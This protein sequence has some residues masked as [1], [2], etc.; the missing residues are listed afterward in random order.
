MLDGAFMQETSNIIEDTLSA[1]N[2]C[3]G[4]KVQ[5]NTSNEGKNFL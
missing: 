4:R 1:Y 5:K 3:K 2:I